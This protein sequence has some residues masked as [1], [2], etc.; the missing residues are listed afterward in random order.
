MALDTLA[1]RL[2][3][4]GDMDDPRGVERAGLVIAVIGVGLLAGIFI[5]TLLNGRWPT[6]LSPVQSLFRVLGDTV[7]DW[8]IVIEFWLFAMPGMIIYW[9]GRAIRSNAG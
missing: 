3:T 1:I 4:G 8:A 6:F 2:Y 9:L 5:L 7:G